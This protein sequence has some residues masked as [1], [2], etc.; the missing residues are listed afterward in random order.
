MKVYITINEDNVVTC[1]S[2]TPLGDSIEVDTDFEELPLYTT[3]YTY[4]GSDLI[5]DEE[6]E[7]EL[8]LKEKE[9]SPPSLSN[10]VEELKRQL[11]ETQDILNFILFEGM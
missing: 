4:N 3:A 8:I 5:H 1:F 2:T 7:A 10:Q 11:L 9:E 6:Y